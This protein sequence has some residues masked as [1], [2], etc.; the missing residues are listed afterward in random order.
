[1][2]K[3]NNNQEKL[4]IFLKNFIFNRFLILFLLVG[5][6]AGFAFNYFKYKPYYSGNITVT[7]IPVS[8]DNLKKD[9]GDKDF[10]Q[11][12]QNYNRFFENWLASVTTQGLVA[13]KI[14]L[15]ISNL[16]QARP[17]YSIQNQGFGVISL[18][19][20]NTDKEKTDKF[21][22]AI[23][24]TFPSL[25]DIWND[26]SNFKLNTNSDLYTKNVLLEYPNWNLHII[27]FLSGFFISLL[28]YILYKIISDSIQKLF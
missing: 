14:G 17:F 7:A 11:F 6:F 22:L 15:K 8:F 13:D 28:F 21:I 12:S 1:M 16:S 2:S 9:L 20:K 23:K 5:L 27:W 25:I 19:F 24:E 26:Q 10:N 18:G 3:S 4:F